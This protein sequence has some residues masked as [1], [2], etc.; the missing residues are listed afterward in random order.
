MSLKE[1]RQ[2]RDEIK[3]QI[4][5]VGSPFVESPRE[6]SQSVALDW[7]SKKV[8]PVRE[9]SHSKRVMGGLRK[10][11][12]P[13]ISSINSGD[14][15]ISDGTMTAALRRLG[16]ASGQF[17]PHGFR[18]MASTN[19]HEMKWPEEAIELQLAHSRGNS[20]AAAY[21]HTEYPDVRRKMMQAWADWLDS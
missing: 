16:Y 7:F 3:I 1:A 11:V 18:S 19:L 10:Y 8:K 9:E 2:K 14:R 12:F 13:A 17:T 15:P 4:S 20:A 21:V 5:R 6:T